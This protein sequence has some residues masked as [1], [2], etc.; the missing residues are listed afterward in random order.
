[1]AGRDDLGSAWLWWQHISGDLAGCG[2]VM[3]YIITAIRGL[4]NNSQPLS[5]LSPSPFYRTSPYQPR[6]QTCCIDIGTLSI[7]HEGNRSQTGSA[8]L[9]LMNSNRGAKI[10]GNW[11]GVIKSNGGGG[12]KTSWSFCTIT[13]PV[14]REL[15]ADKMCAHGVWLRQPW[16]NKSLGRCAFR[17]SSAATWGKSQFHKW[18]RFDYKSLKMDHNTATTCHAPR[19]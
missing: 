12:S 16:Q 11:K 13:M 19:A 14:R 8:L 15:A 1:M 6:N 3:S 4:S 5:V 18:A 7:I 17:Y 2:T 10:A 9:V